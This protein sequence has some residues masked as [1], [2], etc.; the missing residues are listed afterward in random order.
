M[1]KA[2]SL[3]DRI[4]C[5]V[6]SMTSRLRRPRKSIF[7][8]P[9]SSTPCIS[10]C[11]TMG[12]SSGAWPLS[13]LRWIGQVVGERLVGDDHGGGVDAVLAAQALEPL[14]HVDDLLHVGLGLVHGPQLGRG[15]VAVLVLRVRLEAGVQRRVA[16]HHERR[17]G[18]GD[19]VA[20]GVGEPEH[21]GGVAHGGP[22]LDGGERDDL[23]DA[24]PAVLLGRVADHLV[25]EAGVEVHV[26]VGHGDAARVEEALEQQVVADGVEVGDAQAVGHRAPGRAPPPGTDADARCRARSG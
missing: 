22:S 13:G 1:S 7:S 20:D 5:T 3:V 24:V 14:G 26:D 25:A 6:S 15:L 23:G 10:Y 19:L 16:A 8:R 18:L 17:H 2:G 12:A 11:V 4:I 21:A 9:R